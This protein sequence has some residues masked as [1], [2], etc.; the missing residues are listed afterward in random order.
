LKA[1]YEVFDLAEMAG[2]LKIIYTSGHQVPCGEPANA[3]AH[4]Y[5]GDNAA[6]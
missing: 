6:A 2:Q 3:G 1:A 4:K 5:Q